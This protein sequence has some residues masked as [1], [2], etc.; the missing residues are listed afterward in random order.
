MIHAKHGADELH[1]PNCDVVVLVFVIAMP[2]ALFPCF[3]AVA[4]E[5]NW[6]SLVNTSRHVHV[7]PSL[8][9]SFLYYLVQ[10][11]TLDFQ[12]QDNTLSI[13]MSMWVSRR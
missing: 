3:L 8:F 10:V 7:F 12:F 13:S 9:E 4:V 1:P 11:A 6:V 2:D 5:Y